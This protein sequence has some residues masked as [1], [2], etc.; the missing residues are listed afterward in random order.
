MQ[1]G[2]VNVF[3]Y[4]GYDWAKTRKTIEEEV[5]GMRKRLLKIRQLVATGQMQDS[6]IEDTSALLY[7]S[8]RIGLLQ[9]EDALAEPS[10]LIAAIDEELNDDLE[11]SSQS[12][13]QS[14]RPTGNTPKPRIK[15]PQS[16]SLV[17][18]LRRAKVP[19]M[20]FCLSGLSLEFD[21]YRPDDPLV[22]RTFATIKDLEILDHIKSSTWKKFLT[23]LRSDSRG[24]IRETGSN[25]VRIEIRGVRPV[26]GNA[27]EEVRLK[28]CADLYALH[29]LSEISFRQSSCR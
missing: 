10:D 16:S 2:H 9:D 28:V 22:S 3:L 19:S 4:D 27:A 14:L 5:K 20:E 13:W 8:V 21:K 7:N 12:S 29:D 17:K 24:N 6:T 11:T 23:E 26:A 18:R 25:M 1:D 15:A